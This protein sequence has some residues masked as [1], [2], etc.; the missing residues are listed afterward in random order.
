MKKYHRELDKYQ[1]IEIIPLKVQNFNQ[2]NTVVYFADSSLEQNDISKEIWLGKFIETRGDRTIEPITPLVV[3][4]RGITE[5]DIIPYRGQWTTN[6]ADFKYINVLNEQLNFEPI[7]DSSIDRLKKDTKTNSYDFQA[8]CKQ[9]IR[10][11]S[12]TSNQKKTHTKRLSL[13]FFVHIKED[14]S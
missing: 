4:H 14:N 6:Y 10:V 9:K 5:E 11:S 13:N 1:K 2:D 8:Y 3:L 12:F 7:V